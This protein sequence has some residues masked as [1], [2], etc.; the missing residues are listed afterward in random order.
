MSFIA[1]FKD[2]HSVLKKIFRLSFNNLKSIKCW[3][4]FI[5]DEKC[6]K[7]ISSILIT[8]VNNF[9]AFPN[10]N[11][12]ILQ[13]ISHKLKDKV[14]EE[15]YEETIDSNKISG[16]QV[17]I[18]LLLTNKED[19]TSSLKTHVKTLLNQIVQ[20]IMVFHNYCYFKSYVLDCAIYN[21]VLEI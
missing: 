16:L 18:K 15:P 3:E 5:N 14:L 6:D 20:V 19:L 9:K 10:E 13:N 17:A 11:K 4:E 1:N 7:K 8:C 2:N 21:S 12:N